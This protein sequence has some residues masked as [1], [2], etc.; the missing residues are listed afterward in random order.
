MPRKHSHSNVVMDLYS[1]PPSKKFKEDFADSDDDDSDDDND[2]LNYRPFEA[3]IVQ[4]NTPQFQEK[5]VSKRVSPEQVQV[6]L[7]EPSGDKENVVGLHEKQKLAIEAAING[8]NVFITGPG[9]TGKSYVMKKIIEHL[10][11]KYKPEEWVVLAPTGIAAIALDGQTV[12]SFAGCGVPK[13]VGDFSKC[14]GRS[15]EW[16]KLK[17]MLIDEISMLSGE[18]LDNLGNVVSDIRK[19]QVSQRSS[20]AKNKDPNQDPEEQIM[21]EK[22]AV[23]NDS[24]IPFGGCIQ[25]IFCGDFLQLP[26]IAKKIQDIK[27]TLSFGG[28]VTKGQLYCD[29]GFA[30]QSNV[31][32]NADLKVIQLDHIFRQDNKKFQNVLSEIRFGKVSPEIE[33]V[34]KRCDRPLPVQSG[35]R[36]TILYP[37]NMDVASE[38]NKELNQ[39]KGVAK[40]YFAE[41]EI[42]VDSC[43]PTRFMNQAEVTLENHTFFDDCIAQKELTLKVGAQVMLIKNEAIEREQDM[44]KKNNETKRGRSRK[45]ENKESKGSGSQPLVNGSRGVVIGFCTQG[46]H[47]HE[48][49]NDTELH[50]SNKELSPVV[51]FRCGRIKVIE[52]EYFSLDLAGVGRCVRYAMPLKLAWAITVHKAQGMSIDYVKADV[53]H[54]FTEAQT[55]VA[56]S[57]VTDATGLELKGFSCGKVFADKRALAYYENPKGPFPHWNQPWDKAEEAMNDSESVMDVDIP[58]A[59]PGSLQ[60]YL[61]VFTGEPIHI[62]RGQVERLVRDCGGVVRTAVSGKTDYLVIGSKFEDGRDVISGNKY[63][64]AK[65]KKTTILNELDLF[66]LIRTPPE[67]RE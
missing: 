4:K 63:K 21:I 41:D 56:L 18:F 24:A 20:F 46:G 47:E 6:P 13:E 26:P 33:R 2:I 67:R 52:R 10:K 12:H 34:L 36:P 57:R 37:K 25:L 27:A 49:L 43:V 30:F 60:G 35:I 45:K 8:E 3:K 19:L 61:F 11:Y 9:G 31:W 55:Y 62:S 29:R 40:K 66:K 65:E 1:S 32:K 59:K 58:R 53:T 23:K 28:G 16:R 5:N 48:L 39:L 14:W 38:N 15:D 7:V 44:D 22:S 64:K 50:K 51:Q 17:V 42:H 54:V